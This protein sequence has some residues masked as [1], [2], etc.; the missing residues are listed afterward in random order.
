F[1]FTHELTRSALA[2]SF[3]DVDRATLHRLIAT[4]LEGRDA[5]PAML[6]FHWSRASG[7]GTAEKTVTA[8][9]AAGEHAM[10]HLDPHAAMRWF[11]LGVSAAG[12]QRQRAHLLVRVADAASQAGEAGT[13]DALREALRIARALSDPELLS[14]V[15]RV[16]APVWASIPSLEPRERV[17]VR[18]ESSQAA[19]DP[20][21]RAEL[22]GRL[23]TEHLYTRGHARVKPLLDDA[24]TAARESGDGRLLAD[25]LVRHA[26]GTAFPST[27]TERRR[28]LAE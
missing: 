17:A 19:T 5:A 25:V 18:R 16:W 10:R 14:E 13:A 2:E 21:T 4:A 6:A 12:D 26:Y 15:G 9:E 24:L 1:A 27:L 11:E 7:R 20:A 8:A 28:N 22:L 3:D 23:A